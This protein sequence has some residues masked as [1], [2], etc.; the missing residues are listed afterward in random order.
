MR[1][2]KEYAKIL[3]NTKTGKIRMKSAV[4]DN[5]S[6]SSTPIAWNIQ[7]I[8]AED[9]VYM[10]SNIDASIKEEI[11]SKL[12]SEVK[13]P[14]IKSAIHSAINKSRTKIGN[15]SANI[16]FDGILDI[17]GVDPVGYKYN[18]KL[19]KDEN[20]ELLNKEIRTIGSTMRAVGIAFNAIANAGKA[21]NHILQNLN[22]SP[23]D[24]LSVKDTL[25][26]EYGTT[27][28]SSI[29]LYGAI[30]RQIAIASGIKFETDTIS[31]NE[32]YISIGK[33]AVNALTEVAVDEY[34]NGLVKVI[35][36]GQTLNNNF[37]DMFGGNISVEPIIDGA[38]AI[39]INT[40]KLLGKSTKP[41]DK[42]TVAEILNTGSFNTK[43]ITAY[44]VLQA[45]YNA[46]QAINKMTTTQNMEAPTNNSYIE[47]LIKKEELD[48]AD[49]T[50]PPNEKYRVPTELKNQLFT[51]EQGS[52]NDGKQNLGVPDEYAKIFTEDK[53][54][55]SKTENMINPIF[56]DLLSSMSNVFNN[57]SGI[58]DKVSL[59]KVYES[60]GIKD[61]AL[62]NKIFGSYDGAL[63]QE[64]V[65]NEVGMSISKE[66]PLANLLIT[67]DRF[68]DGKKYVKKHK[69]VRNSR[70]MPTSNVLNEI[71]DKMSRS[72]VSGGES[73]FKVGTSAYYKVF[74]SI[75]DEF[76]GSSEIQEEIKRYQAIENEGIN[77]PLDNL[78][79]LFR[80]T[81]NKELTSDQ[82]VSAM[83]TLMKILAK[84]E[85]MVSG[86]AT[87]FKFKTKSVWSAIDS[88]SA[89]SDIR[90][91]KESGSDKITT[92]YRTKSDATASGVILTLYQ[93]LGSNDVADE[94]IKDLLIKMKIA[95]DSGKDLSEDEYLADAYAILR[96]AVDDEHANSQEED[97]DESTFTVMSKFTSLGIFGSI[98]DMLKPVT[99]VKNYQAGAAGTRASASRDMTNDVFEYL[100]TAATSGSTNDRVS[101]LNLLV[102]SIKEVDE[103][104]YKSA[105]LHKYENVLDL[106]KHTELDFAAIP[107]VYLAIQA[108]FAQEGVG[109]VDR[110]AGLLDSTLGQ[111]TTAYKNDLSSYYRN[112]DTFYSDASKHYHDAADRFPRMIIPAGTWMIITESNTDDNGVERNPD[113][114]LYGKTHSEDNLKITAKGTPEYRAWYMKMIKQYG[115]PITSKRQV[116]VESDRAGYVPIKKEL[117]NGLIPAVSGIHSID[118]GL[119]KLAHRNTR[120]IIKQKIL[121][122]NLEVRELNRIDGSD[123]EYI[124]S[125]ENDRDDLLNVLQNGTAGIYDAIH[126]VPVYGDIYDVEYQKLTSEINYE[127]DIS[128]QLVL[129]YDSFQDQI[130]DVGHDENII[131]AEQIKKS[132][133]ID[134]TNNLDSVS[135][136]I[137]KKRKFIKKYVYNAGMSENH[138]LFGFNGNNIAGK[139]NYRLDNNDIESDKKD[140]YIDVTENDNNNNGNNNDADTSS[141][142]D[143]ISSEY[144]DTYAITPTGHKDRPFIDG[145]KISEFVTDHANKIIDIVSSGEPVV[146]IDIEN[147][148]D[149]SDERRYDHAKGGKSKELLQLYARKY[150]YENGTIVQDGDPV[151]FEYKPSSNDFDAIL[152]MKEYSEYKRD[153]PD[154]AKE[155]NEDSVAKSIRDALESLSVDGGKTPIIAYNGI[156]SDFDILSS[157]S[158]VDELLSNKFEIFDAKLLAVSELRDSNE[159]DV[160]FVDNKGNNRTKFDRTQSAVESLL[161]VKKDGKAHDASHDVEVLSNIIGELVKRA[162][163]KTLDINKYKDNQIISEFIKSENVKSLTSGSEFSYDPSVHGITIGTKESLSGSGLDIETA[164]A[165]EIVHYSTVGY[166]Y[167]ASG[168]SDQNAKY[169]KKTLEIL[170][171]LD[172]KVINKLPKRIQDVL[173]IEDELHRTA[174]FEAVM[175][176]EDSTAKLT[177]AAIKH[178]NKQSGNIT[179]TTLK[180]NVIKLWNNIKGRISKVTNKQFNEISSKEIVDAD[181][182]K[183]AIHGVMASGVRFN[184]AGKGVNIRKKISNK[185]NALFINGDKIKL[186][187]Q[188][189]LS[190]GKHITFNFNPEGEY[191]YGPE[192]PGKEGDNAKVTVIG[193]FKNDDMEYRTVLVEANGT[194][195]SR[196]PDGTP[197]H[198]TDYVNK[199]N[200][201]KPFMTGK[202]A[203]ENYNKI[204][205]LDGK[206]YTLDATVDVVY[207]TYN[208]KYDKSSSSSGKAKKQDKNKKEDDITNTVHAGS[209]TDSQ[210]KDTKQK[211][212]ESLKE[213]M[214]YVYKGKEHK[215]DIDSILDKSLFMLNKSISNGLGDIYTST[216]GPKT[217]SGV[218]KAH[219]FMYQNFDV[220]KMQFDR[221]EDYWG[222]ADWL[223]SLK[224]Y[225]DTW[226][227]LGTFD[228]L[229]SAITLTMTSAQKRKQFEDN[230]ISKLN[231]L[232][233]HMSDRD[234]DNIYYTFARSPIFYLIGSNEIMSNLINKRAGDIT[235]AIDEYIKE[236]ESK[237]GN[238]SKIHRIRAMAQIYAGKR[239][240]SRTTDAYN[241]AQMHP[242]D[243]AERLNLGALL[244]LY[245]IKENT[246][247]NKEGNT[248]R[249]YENAF[250]LLRKNKKFA[251]ELMTLSAGMFGSHN[252]MYAT[253]KDKMLGKENLLYESFTVPKEFAIVTKKDLNHNDYT[254]ESG[255]RILQKPTSK[256]YGIVYRDRVEQTSQEGAGTSVHYLNQDIIV[257]KDKELK[258]M[259]NVYSIKTLKG[260]FQKI[261]LT[262][263]QLD[264]LGLNKNPADAIVRSYGRSIE[265]HNTQ[266]ARDELLSQTMTKYLKTS[267]SIDKLEEDLADID[268]KDIPLFLSLPDSST[269][270]EVLETHKLIGDRYK[271]VSNVTTVGG[272]NE[273]LHLVRK[274]FSDIAIGF[275]DPV[276]F[277]NNDSLKKAAFAIRQAVKLT[278]IHW[279]ITNIPKI[280]G[281]TTSNVAILLAYGVPVQEIPRLIKESI[282]DMKS[283]EKLRLKQLE[284]EIKKYSGEDVDNKLK[285]VKESIKTHPM[286]IMLNTGMMQSISVEVMNKDESVISGLQNDIESLLNK[287][288]KDSNGKNNGLAKAIKA[289][290]QSGHQ[291]MNVET[292]LQFAGKSAKNFKALQSF[293]DNLIESGDR[294]EHNKKTGDMAK[295]I[296]EFIAS[297]DSAMVR[298]GSFAVQSIDIVSR[299]ILLDTLIAQGKSEHDAIKITLESFVDYKIN[300]PKE[301][302]ALS[303]YGVLLFP[304]FWMRIQKVILATVK[305]N[306]AGVAFGTSIQQ[307]I[308]IHPDTIID[309]N[310][311]VKMFG[312]HFDG[313]GLDF[314]NAPLLSSDAFFPQI[315]G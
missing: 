167:S 122:I 132:I 149:P 112:I 236:Y 176:A 73:S 93:A 13:I 42:N 124:R 100:D 155:Y 71:S 101:A 228:S 56:N 150:K 210:P 22:L 103:D 305:A 30:G 39:Y 220:Y 89:I 44:P 6:G 206:E 213:T 274:D 183:L 74:G 308:D 200:G 275:N 64:R 223:Q 191:S 292:L 196:Q 55:L 262:P 60:I 242:Q 145:D 254:K 157:Y 115:M 148:F 123:N 198:I 185:F 121:D 65:D 202:H 59:N 20:E 16:L 116:L 271:V 49:D 297:P 173:K 225:L 300:M 310:I 19:S 209:S 102:S 219:E 203:R 294:I 91:A 111:A 245:S 28:L 178:I 96:K 163:N 154:S 152:D 180:N 279:V 312:K 188:F 248:V 114:I 194:V 134:N 108:Y 289:L 205:H 36:N 244:A 273:H 230:K 165:H 286:A 177:Y 1:K 67:F 237:I 301:V 57:D 53:V 131:S 164:I 283:L 299:K 109:L 179:S 181:I 127:Y 33:S 12:D 119:E 7:S 162:E 201:I 10:M 303:D 257:P 246:R 35:E 52:G 107:G 83:S 5:S 32:A 158:G 211:A 306:P 8:K 314:I 290:S 171:R 94:M 264:L 9:Y 168:K 298:F 126:S 62:K 313:N 240:P 311:I 187:S 41:E 86:K 25:K 85:I 195:Y 261:V 170:S 199:D 281:D 69:I 250:K 117:S 68:K 79:K 287:F 92:H 207:G 304:S 136:K 151:T 282:V 47:K 63:T 160:E 267:S 58:D 216:I 204:T 166:L 208:E 133:F 266:A 247:I 120:R 159:D 21:E 75:V 78:V 18:D 70:S 31:A 161:G 186:F 229:N 212:E 17:D 97:T 174:E 260:S 51:V 238:T 295:Y 72:I 90:S 95:K 184:N 82:R 153:I 255:W 214:S 217:E 197:L 265:I 130:A 4:L 76:I 263:D 29:N 88:L 156:K 252:K 315:V 256:D 221:A 278:K 231:K 258:G 50:I 138:L 143:E 291:S 234:K 192:I 125:L 45:T 105:E 37:K 113:H 99:M 46:S 129:L 110:L 34:G 137:D 84:N 128:E 3:L 146:V 106:S 15:T 226:G 288:L 40:T 272:I 147:T 251:S 2:C 26:S 268:T 227:R 54:G 175:V 284:L 233:E 193:H 235:I 81:Q 222:S 169:I 24:K 118:S 182:L 307:F 142:K 27:I 215:V 270:K 48:A 43:K 23:E 253:T 61:V 11:M 239:T 249:E 309:S 243:S 80:K 218:A 241:I 14:K 302:K 190:D 285:R 98:R 189:K 172:E 66:T 38:D 77:K 87:K 139:E 277:S 224:G 296:S 135:E 144:L 259:N 280:F 276:L 269:A 140:T 141:W 104:L 232:M 293:G